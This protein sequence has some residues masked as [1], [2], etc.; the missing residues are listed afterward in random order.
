WQ[1]TLTGGTPATSAEKNPA[2]IIYN[3]PGTYPVKL[4]AWNSNGADSIVKTN[5]ITVGNAQ[6]PAV[7]FT[8]D[9][10]VLCEGDYVRFQDLS[11][12]CPISWSWE[13]APATYTFIQGTSANSQNPVVQFSA[14]GLY[15]VRLTATN[16]T[17]TNSI[18]K[19]EYIAY[20]G[21]TL[22]FT[23]SF[24]N[25]FD[26]QHW[27]ILNSDNDFTWDTI[28]VP[29]TVSGNV[30]AWIN[31]YNYT[32]PNRDQLISP[33]LNLSNYTSATLT[34]QHAYAQHATVKDS[35]I[36][37]ISGDCGATWTRLLAAGPD[38]TPNVFA[39]HAN[40][41]D[42]FYPESDYDW[43]GSAYGTSCYSLDI[44][45]WVGQR[46]VKILFESYNRR[47]NNIFLDNISISGPVGIPGTETDNQEIRIYPNPSTG[48]MTLFMTHP[49][50]NVDLSVLNLQG[51]TVY[52]ENFISSGDNN[53]R[54][55]N[56]SG[57][58]KGVYFLRF[59]SDHSSVVKKII[60]E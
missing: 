9:K 41:S 44:N 51:Q 59:I 15:S 33:P 19:T 17:G 35:L 11:D 6:A 7:D 23:E 27:I 3:T 10:T 29:N 34:F 18:T 55:L 21:Y 60:L 30:A 50:G 12:H 39:T 32:R 28:H 48:E 53:E 5:Y 58:S 14:P 47:G 31:L 4:K 25:G 43:C 57:L 40:M 37:K 2:G 20:G 8:A 46:N 45:A 16:S 52:R 49:A 42:A 26:R 38:G 13:L 1:W 54:H 22:P 24:E 36:V 56:L